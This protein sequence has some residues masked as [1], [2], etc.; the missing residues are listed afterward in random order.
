MRDIAV[1]LVI[2]ADGSVA[3]RALDG[4]REA[5]AR[6][7]GEVTTRLQG[8]GDAAG[9]L[10]GR[11][12]NVR[13]QLLAMAGAAAAAFATG[14]VV[15]AADAYTRMSGQLTLATSS[16]QQFNAAQGQV[17]A[18]AQQTRQPLEAVTGLYA[19][20]SQSTQE[21]GTSQQQLSTVTRAVS[22]A[23]V[24]SGA[25]AAAADGAIVQLGQA[26]ASGSL[27]GDEFNSI[28]EAAP[29]L[30]R[31]LADSL[32][33][34]TGALRKM[35]EQGQLT[36]EVLLRALSGD[37]AAKIAAEFAKLPPTI[38]GAMTVAGNA[39]TRFVGKL[40]QSTGASAAFA[41]AII[42]GAGRLDALVGPATTLA[43]ALA[44]VAGPLALGAVAIGLGRAAQAGAGW[45]ANQVAQVQA[46]R[47][48]AA[49]DSARLDMIA[50]IDAAKVRSIQVERNLAE[51]TVA[52]ARAD[53]TAAQDALQRARLD[54]L[55]A[56]QEEDALK[57]QV[58]FAGVGGAALEQANKRVTF[59]LAARER[60]SE[61]VAAAT[62]QL[63]AAERA[64]AGSTLAL[65][66]AQERAAVSGNVAAAATGG[67]LASVRAAGSGLVAFLGGPWGALFAAL[68][69]GATLWATWGDAGTKAA[70][71]VEAAIERT[72]AAVDGQR[73]AAEQ[74]LTQEQIYQRN[75]QTRQ[76]VVERLSEAQ[77]R[78]NELLAMPQGIGQRGDFAG[79]SAMAAAS[80]EIERL[81]GELQQ[82][83]SAT[84]QLNTTTTEWVRASAQGF[85]DVM[86]AADPVA[87]AIGRV[88]DA[89]RDANAEPVDLKARD[90]FNG[91]LEDLKKQ[92]Q[93][94]REQI[95]SA[96]GGAAAVA[97]LRAEQI[98]A[99]NATAEQRA[100]L[101]RLTGSITAL[102]GKLEATRNATRG[103]AQA[104]RDHNAAAREAKSAVD[105]YNGAMRQAAAQDVP[106]LTRAALDQVAALE[107]LQGIRERL[108]RTGQLTGERE[109]ALLAE[110]TRARERYNRVVDQTIAAQQRSRAAVDALIPQIRAEAAAV[111]LSAAERERQE[112]RL[113]AE[114]EMR[115]RL[116][117]AIR[118]G[119]AGLEAESEARIRAAGEAAAAEVALRQVDQAAQEAAANTE[120]YWGGLGDAISNTLGEGLVS[121][122]KGTADRLKDIFKRLLADL[123][124]S[125]A[126]QRLVI[127]LFTQLGIPTGGMQAGNLL[128]TILGGGQPTGGGGLLSSLLGSGQPPGFVGPPAP[129]PA[130]LMQG[131]LSSLMSIFSNPLSAAATVFAGG[132]AIARLL[133]GNGTIGGLAGGLVGALFGRGFEP[134]GS[135]LELGLGSGGA[136]ASLTEQQRRRGS[137]FGGSSRR[138]DVERDVPE[139]AQSAIDGA[140][141]RVE[142]QMAARGALFGERAPEIVGG[143]FRRV[144]DAAGNLIKEE[145]RVLGVLR[146]ET[147]EQ[148]ANRALA[149]STIALIDRSLNTG[150]T[151]VAQSIG[152]A[153][154]EAF[155]GGAAAA[156]QYG[157]ELEGG[158]TTMLK[159]ASTAVQGEASRI[160]ERWRSDAD[161][162][163][164]GANFLFAAA[165][166]M[167]NGL[168]L[169]TDGTL[170]QVAD[171]VEDLAAEG[172]PLANAYARVSAETQL[173]RTAL[174]LMG[175][176]TAEV[177]EAMV[178]RASE[179]SAA[180]GGLDRARELWDGYFN[181]FY[182]AAERAQ[183]AVDEAA[184]R[185]A[186]ALDALGLDNS[187]SNEEFRRA[188]ESAAD[189]LSAEQTVRYLEAAEA[190]RVFNA[191]VAQAAQAA[192]TG[193]VVDD[194]LSGRIAS[195]VATGAT[196]LRGSAE[197]I[198]AA[199][200]ALRREGESAVEAYERLSAGGA[201]L[202][203]AL[204]LLGVAFEGSAE[205]FAAAAAGVSSDFGRL[206]QEF[207]ET[208]F[209]PAEQAARRAEI[210]Q[211]NYAAAVAAAGMAV[212]QLATREQIRAAV[213]QALAEGNTTLAEQLLRVASAFN[214]VEQAAGVAAGAVAQLVDEWGRPVGGGGSN[215]GGGA[216]FGGNSGGGLVGVGNE[217][218]GPGAGTANE[219][220]RVRQALRDWWRD[221]TT[222]PL[223]PLTPQQQYAE[224]L[225]E[226]QAAAAAAQA[227]D[228][229]A[230]RRLQS[231]SDG[232]LR[233][234]QSYLGPGAAYTQLF[235]QVRQTVGGIAGIV[236]AGGNGIGPIDGLGDSAG[237]AASSLERLASAAGMAPGSLLGGLT[238]T[239]GESI[240]GAWRTQS[241][242]LPAPRVVQIDRRPPGADEFA[243]PRPVTRPPVV[244]PTDQAL[245]AD[246]TAT[247]LRQLI[248]AVEATGEKQI[249]AYEK[250]KPLGQPTRHLMG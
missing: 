51:V 1:R 173:Y 59:S 135:T 152:D 55:R 242:Q 144:Y 6:A 190:I 73:A 13:G 162:L 97:Q 244:P 249:R 186:T 207:G 192:G 65:A 193:T 236:D 232:L 130:G 215:P 47:L 64:A 248:R 56:K 18:I 237:R 234:A 200:Q 27:R 218:G 17:F 132:S 80:A 137:L 60:A 108:A 222:G 154:G 23:M 235:N 8:A 122:F 155:Q 211:A 45:V 196:G 20:L 212:D 157:S 177:G 58:Q 2:Q 49:A 149:E 95:A 123:A 120:R 209:T 118:D 112:A 92:E 182:S 153:A 194:G 227:G 250:T 25:S 3:V 83:D 12:D 181:E 66:A 199:V 174:D 107:R 76:G 77:A 146:N 115:R 191:A 246:P 166:D 175:R 142:Q 9:G 167:R 34:G 210:A 39:V 217:G 96:Q 98:G 147:F 159:G 24:I 158:I 62:A 213:M 30:M 134:Q 106:A 44:T 69:V 43:T 19:R 71:E 32:G 111:G 31:A 110:D 145:S 205:Q 169:L 40:D 170:T 117:V 216:V 179:I 138:R 229:E 116:E 230:A 103:A 100:E 171:L 68:T 102:E 185:R 67:F 163:L 150:A 14:R 113:R 184:R 197:E 136:T 21:L 125:I 206:A 224:S 223:S 148:F 214:A 16:T 74:A 180:A 183:R 11:L 161:T 202:T 231:L 94:L 126:A 228:I 36:S 164:D 225:R 52:R 226:W 79:S 61:A 221:L 114:E 168:G 87:A 188:F 239:I 53:Q 131:G 57:R 93:A 105:E 165:L 133:G 204:T 22:Q 119:N 220:E 121:G 208:Y 90:A 151:A 70:T 72:R 109:A 104:T 15:Q 99:S 172:E 75:L 78:L 5:G 195:D 160:A 42:D 156:G 81:R 238:E 101:D 201:T 28:N 38:E 124:A 141:D 91:L 129:G 85:L 187:I 245:E 41:Q 84:G 203:E 176:S 139:E 198:G 178:R 26:F 143:T 140:F 4:V 89:I 86:T 63:A 37:Q 233:Q 88:R 247:L 35:A 7:G 82:L 54:V 240:A 241:M 48:A 243:R 127:P 46:S 189:S 219:L 50:S 33:V 128:Q 10:A 29:R